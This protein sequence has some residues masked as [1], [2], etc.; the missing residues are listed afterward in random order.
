MCSG[1]GCD[2]NAK[3]Q[4][5]MGTSSVVSLATLQNRIEIILS[6]YTK[7]ALV[8]ANNYIV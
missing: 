5:K 1:Q 8:E 4:T 3:V 6:S 2:G 7:R